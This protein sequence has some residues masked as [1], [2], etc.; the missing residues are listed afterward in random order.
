MSRDGSQL[1]AAGSPC[2]PSALSASSSSSSSSSASASASSLRLSS[3]AA[4]ASSST[5][6][7]VP[8]SHGTRPWLLVAQARQE[9]SLPMTE[10]VVSQARRTG[11][12][13]RSHQRDNGHSAVAGMAGRDRANHPSNTYCRGGATSST[14]PFPSFGASSAARSAAASQ[15]STLS[16]SRSDV[17]ATTSS[18]LAATTASSTSAYTSSSFMKQLLPPSLPKLDELGD[19]GKYIL[20][21]N[22]QRGVG[23]HQ[24]TS[25]QRRSRAGTGVGGGAGNGV[26][27]GRRNRRGRRVRRSARGDTHFIHAPVGSACAVQLDSEAGTEEAQ[28]TSSF[29]SVASLST[30]TSP[31]TTAAATNSSTKVASTRSRDSTQARRR[32]Q[33][34]SD[35]QLRFLNEIVAQRKRGNAG[36]SSIAT[37]GNG[38]GPRPAARTRGNLAP[39]RGAGNGVVRGKAP[40]IDPLGCGARALRRLQAHTD[41]VQTNNHSRAGVRWSGS[42][43]AQIEGSSFAAANSTG[44]DHTV[45][46]AKSPTRRLPAATTHYEAGGAKAGAEQ[47]DSQ[48]SKIFGEQRPGGTRKSFKG[49]VSRKQRRK[50]RRAHDISA[51]A[52]AAHNRNAVA[53]NA[54]FDSR[55]S[56]KIES[57]TSNPQIASASSAPRL[58]KKDAT[59]EVAPRQHLLQLPPLPHQF[60]DLRR[61]MSEAEEHVFSPALLVRL[62]KALDGCQLGSQ[63]GALSGAETPNSTICGKDRSVAVSATV[64]PRSKFG[65]VDASVVGKKNK[66]L[67]DEAVLLAGTLEQ[68][69][70]GVPQILAE[71]RPFFACGK[72]NL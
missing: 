19:V 38:N 40:G 11:A 71:V 39:T 51:V 5:S 29:P 22:M 9:S 34:T 3:E 30:T 50:V 48:R 63:C 61:I 60:Q 44:G 1:S 32:D 67:Y 42:P 66:A 20:R 46:S 23:L 41:N 70:C 43:Y 18:K 25:C 6:S 65:C 24:N 15:L 54:S 72:N 64:P 37:T 12:V 21:G 49:R 8:L 10:S 36:V 7:L 33:H 59:C 13:P 57:S 28:E 62:R 53:A 58:V 68:Q 31:S 4:S 45:F 52:A 16:R 35:S 14:M 56:E 2:S 26:G 55:Q 27:S 47:L 17:S 69:F